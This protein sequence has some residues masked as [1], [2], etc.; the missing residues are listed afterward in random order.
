MIKVQNPEYEPRI[1]EYLK[2]NRF[3][4]F[5]GFELNVIK[6]GLTEGIMKIEDKHFQQTGLFHGG[7]I[8]SVADIVAGFAAFTTVS[9]DQYVLTSEIKVSYF[10]PGKGENL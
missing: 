4:N 7:L 8:A 2:R 6:P 10:R 9:A 3:M 5:I 1:K